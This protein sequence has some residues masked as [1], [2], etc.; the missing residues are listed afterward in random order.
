MKKLVLGLALL[1]TGMMYGQTVKIDTIT[2]DMSDS[3]QQ[4]R[5]FFVCRRINQKVLESHRT[6]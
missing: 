6:L 2:D 3:T 4:V 1:A 5:I